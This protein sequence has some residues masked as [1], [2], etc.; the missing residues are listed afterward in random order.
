[1]EAGGSVSAREV[2]AEMTSSPLR[3]E[4]HPKHLRRPSSVIPPL[5]RLSCTGDH[6]PRSGGSWDWTSS[7]EGAKAGPQRHHPITRLL[8]SLTAGE[9]SADDTAMAAT[10]MPPPPRGIEPSDSPRIKK[11][12]RAANSGSVLQM[13]AVRELDT[14]GCDH[15]SSANATPVPRAPTTMTPEE[16]IGT[17]S[18]RGGGPEGAQW[19]HQQSTPA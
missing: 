14:C 18:T 8:R 5:R 17:M 6:T 1:L 13:M 11:A 16:R 3:P 15:A 12:K 9:L 7:C 4:G 10:I 19:T 2:S